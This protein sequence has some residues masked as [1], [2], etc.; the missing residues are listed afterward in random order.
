MTE[1]YL[2]NL[3][4]SQNEAQKMREKIEIGEAKSYAEA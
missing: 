2:Y 3:E 4:K 1:R